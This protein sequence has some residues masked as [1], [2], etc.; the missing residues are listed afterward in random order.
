VIELQR[1]LVRKRT[2]KMHAVGHTHNNASSGATA[3]NPIP[4]D[5]II[6]LWKPSDRI[7]H[8]W[9]PSDRII[10]LCVN[11][12][13]HPRVQN[14]VHRLRAL[15]PQCDL[16]PILCNQRRV[17]SGCKRAFSSFSVMVSRVHGGEIVGVQT[18]RQGFGRNLRCDR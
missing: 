7:I 17:E 16:P 2:P 14:P 10:H 6:H 12:I 9:K 13:D 3:Y 18:C 1:Q 4:S 11:R 5:R 8:L 15:C